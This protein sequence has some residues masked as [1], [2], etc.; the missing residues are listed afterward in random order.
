MKGIASVVL[1][2]G[3]TVQLPEAVNVHSLRGDGRAEALF[4]PHGG[5]AAGG[6][7]AR[8][9]IDAQGVGLG[10]DNGFALIRRKEDG[11]RRKAHER[12][13]EGGFG[14]DPC[15]LRGIA[16]AQEVQQRKAQDKIAQTLHLEYENG[17]HVS[18]SGGHRPP[19]WRRCGAFRPACP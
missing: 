19:A 8:A 10:N 17:S 14:H 5:Q 13:E 3:L 16:F 6:R 1:G 12:P 7:R 2:Q 9:E 4:C 15:G 11:G 18:M